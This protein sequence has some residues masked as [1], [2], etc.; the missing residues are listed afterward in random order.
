M[1]WPSHAALMLLARWLS[2]WA[3]VRYPKDRNSW[4]RC[5]AADRTNTFSHNEDFS[6]LRTKTLTMLT[7]E[8]QE[9]AGSVAGRVDEALQQSGILHGACRRN[10]SGAWSR[11][12][13]SRQGSG[14]LCDRSDVE[15]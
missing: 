8:I 3:E 5:I 6:N 15:K 14:K 2:R 4:P 9:P 11:K 1:T 12:R 10:E 13:R 7:V